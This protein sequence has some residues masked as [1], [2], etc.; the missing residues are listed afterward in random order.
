MKLAKDQ[1]GTIPNA[2]KALINLIGTINRSLLLF[3]KRILRNNTNRI[4][5][6]RE[7]N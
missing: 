1:C 4:V 2:K 3:P 6:F 7:T 5:A